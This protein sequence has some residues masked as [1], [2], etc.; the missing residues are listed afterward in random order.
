MIALANTSSCAFHFLLKQGISQVEE[1]IHM[2]NSPRGAL[3]SD[4]FDCIRQ[5][6]HL[7]RN[8]AQHR[9]LFSAM[10]RRQ[11]GRSPLL[12]AF[13]YGAQTD[14]ALHP[15]HDP[16]NPSRWLTAAHAWCRRTLLTAMLAMAQK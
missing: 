2:G 3:P 12:L 5:V 14:Q 10:H 15:M 1:V 6:L 7:P 9:H 13:S 4:Q 16:R 8:V 11:Q